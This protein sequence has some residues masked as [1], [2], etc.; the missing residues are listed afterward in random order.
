MTLATARILVR[1]AVAAAVGAPAG[2]AGGGGTPPPPAPVSQ[3][4]PLSSPAPSLSPSPSPS[5]AASAA[6]VATGVDGL[7]RLVAEAGARRA[8]ARAAHRGEAFSTGSLEH[9][10]SAIEGYIPSVRLD[11]QTFIGP[12]GSAFAFYLNGMHNRIHPI[13]AD[14]FLDSLDALPAGDPMNDPHLVTRLEIVLTPQG[15]LQKMGVVKSSGVT[16]FDLG[17]LASVERASPYGP[18]PSAIVSSDGNVYIQWELHR[19]G[20]FACSTIGAQPYLLT[21]AAP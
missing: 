13:F 4:I 3:A 8:E 15:T 19:D 16:A 14:W 6:P 9:W 18:V 7:R 2:G 10:R 1:L 11:N 12:A 20:V 5:L 21:R 17:A